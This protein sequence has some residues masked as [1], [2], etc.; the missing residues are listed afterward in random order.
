MFLSMYKSILAKTQKAL[1]T[2]QMSI[3]SRKNK[4]YSPEMECY[5]A[6]KMKKSA[7]YKMN[8]SQK[9]ILN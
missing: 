3:K 1:E 9:V 8:K 7:V 2:T 6:G 5:A 4:L